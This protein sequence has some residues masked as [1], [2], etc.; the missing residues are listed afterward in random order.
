MIKNPIV[1]KV[2][3]CT[4][5]FCMISCSQDDKPI[6]IVLEQVERGAVLRTQEYRN[7]DF[8]ITD[9]TSRFSVLIEEDDIE[10]GGLLEDVDVYLQYKGNTPETSSLTTQKI[11]YDTFEKEQFFLG[12]TGRPAIDIEFTFS[13]ALQIVGL[14]VDNV[15]V[16]DQ[17]VVN[18]DL[19]LTDGRTFNMENSSSIIIAYD[20]FFSSPFCYTINVVEPINETA[21]TGVYMIESILDGPFD[22]GTFVDSEIVEVTKGR[23]NTT[24]QFDAWHFLHHR[25]IEQKRRWEFNIVGDETVFGKNQLSSPEGY[26]TRAAAPLLLG[27]G[28]SNGT[29]DSIDDT[30]FELWFVEGYL[31]FDGNCGFGTAPSRYRFTKQ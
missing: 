2:L 24:R 21:F 9:E 30:V 10:D 26:C 20:T 8:I 1:L 28:D 22:G 6:D 27:P 12:P 25:G 29:A 14:S 5:L 13:E 15:V 18:L 19:N 31:G 11:L 7:N 23:S 4:L 17:F 16:K 3:I